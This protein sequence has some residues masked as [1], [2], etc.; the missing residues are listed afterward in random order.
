VAAAFLD[1]GLADRLEIFT[2]PMVLGA[3]GH[4]SIDALAALTLDEAPRFSRI[5]IRKLGSDL[6][7]SYA[8]R[9]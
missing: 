3:A 5:S 4:G 9:A 1:R 8:A 2:A 7:E 6:L